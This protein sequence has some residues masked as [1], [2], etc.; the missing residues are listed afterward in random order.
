MCSGGG[1]TVFVQCATVSVVSFVFSD[2]TCG[3]SVGRRRSS[4]DAPGVFR[5]HA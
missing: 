4:Y 5:R 3:I 1:L 2:D